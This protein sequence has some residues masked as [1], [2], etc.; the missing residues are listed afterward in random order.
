MHGFVVL[1]IKAGNAH[2][3]LGV[4]MVVSAASLTPS[5]VLHCSKFYN[6][7][8]FFLLYTRI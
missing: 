8:R 1:H 3:P 6:K 2:F 5:P 4:S 7:P